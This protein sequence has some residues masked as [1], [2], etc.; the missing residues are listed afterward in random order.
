[1]DHFHG[2]PVR[3]LTSEVL[4]LD[5]LATAGPRLVG[6][7]YKG[8]ENLLAEVP[9]ISLPTPYGDYRYLGGHRLWHAPEATPRSYVPDDA[10]LESAEQMSSGMVLRGRVESGTG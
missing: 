6:L 1:M 7:R 5:F 9:G 2:Y 8:S 4:E 3:H 10:G